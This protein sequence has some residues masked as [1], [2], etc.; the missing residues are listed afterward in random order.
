MPFLE[1]DWGDQLRKANAH[2]YDI[3]QIYKIH[4]P[5]LFAER[6]NHQPK[7]DILIQGD[8]GLS[9]NK[10]ALQKYLN[11]LR[12]HKLEG[13]K[14]KELPVS[15]KIDQI[16]FSV[17][18]GYTDPEFPPAPGLLRSGLLPGNFD[19]EVFIDRPPSSREEIVHYQ[20]DIA[21]SFFLEWKELDW[22]IGFWKQFNPENPN[23]QEIN[24]NLTAL[25]ETLHIEQVAQQH[26]NLS[27]ALDLAQ[28][29]FGINSLTTK[30]A[31][32]IVGR[33]YNR[34][35]IHRL[36]ETEAEAY[37]IR[38]L[39]SIYEEKTAPK[40]ITLEKPTKLYKYLKG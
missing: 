23:H 33:V 35:Q 18:K 10:T 6:E 40:I 36:T 2:P 12:I 8:F 37:S 1:L 24:L 16:S 21:I 5:Y 17:M 29:E 9:V 26:I 34:V 38:V 25:H 3:L 11:D 27:T 39:M 20:E 15:N 32:T 22:I 30:E 14:Y 19:I 7:I 13:D 31:M 4:S 28:K